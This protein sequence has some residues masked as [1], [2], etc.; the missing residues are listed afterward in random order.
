MVPT[1]SAKVDW[2]TFSG[3]SGFDSLIILPKQQQNLRQSPLAEIEEL[4]DQVFLDS[5]NPGK[6]ICN[7]LRGKLRVL[8]ERA[9][10]ALLSQASDT[11]LRN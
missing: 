9:N 5:N 11:G 2:L 10:H 3:Y 1:I 7:K 8:L 4:I 6:Q